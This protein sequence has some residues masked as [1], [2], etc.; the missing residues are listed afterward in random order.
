MPITLPDDL[1][2]DEKIVGLAIDVSQQPAV[3]I[4]G[5]RAR[6]DLHAYSLPFEQA[7]GELTGFPAKAFDRLARIPCFRRVYSD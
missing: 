3:S 4:A 1:F 2:V 6:L 5:T 7:R